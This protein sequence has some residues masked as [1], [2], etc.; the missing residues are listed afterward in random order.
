MQILGRPVDIQTQIRPFGG[1]LGFAA[2]EG[3][4]ED[5]INLLH[6]QPLDGVVLVHEYRQG[7]DRD[8]DGSRL[9]AVTLLEC[10]LFTGLHGTAHGAK[11]GNALGQR[12]RRGGR[13]GG[14]DLHV[15][16]GV[17]TLKFFGPQGHHVG[18]GVRADRGQVARDAT[19]RGVIR[20]IFIHTGSQGADRKQGCCGE[21]DYT[22][23][24]VEFHPISPK[25]QKAIANTW[26][27]LTLSCGDQAGCISQLVEFYPSPLSQGD[28]GSVLKT[29]P[30]SDLAVTN[31]WN[32][33]DTLMT[34]ARRGKN[35]KG[36]A[37]TAPFLI[38]NYLSIKTIL[39]PPSWQE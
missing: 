36:A 37:L 39:P 7:I 31:L 3:A 15:D 1:R 9:V 24:F 32:L 29:A 27:R 33:Y 17:D 6:G 2:L 8:A 21:S 20:Q 26:R 13:T 19:G 23:Q 25:L 14:L 34:W 12:G 30:V 18:Q 4:G 22:S 11:L 38:A 10:F 16:V 35:A 5:G 28:A